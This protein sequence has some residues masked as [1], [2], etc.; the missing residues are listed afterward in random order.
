MIWGGMVGMVILEEKNSEKLQWKYL[1]V[2]HT[3][4]WNF[5]ARQ[6]NYTVF[7]KKKMKQVACAFPQITNGM[8]LIAVNKLARILALPGS[9]VLY[10]YIYT[11]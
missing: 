10:L 6:N 2:V 3:L 4:S 9:S 1:K 5:G 11:S 8:S 7:E